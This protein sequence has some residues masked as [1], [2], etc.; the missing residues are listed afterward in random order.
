[1]PRSLA[2]LHGLVVTMNSS[3]DVME[4]GGI[5][6]E[7]G[8]ILKVGTAKE[9]KESFS[10]DYEIDATGKVVIPGLI[11]SHR[12]LYG[13][14]TRGMPVKEAPKSFIGFLEDFWWPLVEDLSLIHI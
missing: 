12:H 5:Y 4:D 6:I 8:R 9:I 11:D 10:F 3:R 7:E 13:I 14:L 1:M 2:V